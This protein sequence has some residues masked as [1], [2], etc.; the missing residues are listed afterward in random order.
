MNLE[1]V[2]C[3]HQGAQT[4]DE[5][6][7]SMLKQLEIHFKTGPI[8]GDARDV[9]LHLCKNLYARDLLLDVMKCNTVDRQ[10]MFRVIMNECDK[11]DDE[12]LRKRAAR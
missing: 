2:I 11:R 7:E 9:L 10:D 8:I 3:E 12:I 5:R 1:T 4:T 6:C